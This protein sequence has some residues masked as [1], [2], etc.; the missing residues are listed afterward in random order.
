MSN[1]LRYF[2]LTTAIIIAGC[3]STP[4]NTIPTVDHVD[5]DRFMGDWYVIAN[6]PTFVEAGAHNAVESYERIDERTIATTFRFNKDQFDGKQKVYH[7]TGY[8]KDD[9]SNA[10]WGMQFIWPFQSEYRIVYLD[11]TYSQ[12]IIGRSKRDY[13][14]IMSRFPRVGEADYKKLLSIVEKLGY[15]LTKVQKVPQNWTDKARP[16][17]LSMGRAVGE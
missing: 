8:V 15:D 11:P 17:G 14:W 5:L 12:T 16:E 2:L 4:M 3:G 10:V 13:V 6:I 1:R 7:P 9:V